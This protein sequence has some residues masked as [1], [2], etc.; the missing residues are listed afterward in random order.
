MANISVSPCQFQDNDWQWEETEFGFS[1]LFC[2]L[3]VD[4]I[5]LSEFPVYALSF[6]V[7]ILEV[8]P[9]IVPDRMSIG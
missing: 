7:E 1:I 2:R 6:E 8:Y 3:H 9:A 4:V 5:T